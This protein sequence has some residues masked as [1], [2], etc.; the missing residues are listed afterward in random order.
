MNK[1]KIG[2][3]ITCLITGKVF[4]N[5][6]DMITKVESV[7]VYHSGALVIRTATNDLKP[8]VNELIFKNVSS[9]IVLNSLKVSNKEVTV[10]NKSIIRKLSEEEFNQLLDQK[11]ALTKQMTLIESKF[12]EQGFVSKVEDLEKLTNFYAVKILEIKKSL[13]EIERQIEEAKKLEDIE[14][15]N[16]DAAILKLVVSIDGKLKDP[17]KMQYVCGGIGWSSAY[18]MIVESSANKTIEVNVFIRM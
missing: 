18:E 4:A 3:L 14:I 16:E 15:E 12:N 1:L 17:F 7:T 2:L 11:D 9:K 13:R 5:E 6:I 8:G 10:L